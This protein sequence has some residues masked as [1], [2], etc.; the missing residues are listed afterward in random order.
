MRKTTACLLAALLLL[1]LVG[2]ERAPEVSVDSPETP[3]ASQTNVAPVQVPQK[4]EAD[5]VEAAFGIPIVLPANE[6]WIAED[7]YRLTGETDLKVTYRDMIAESECTL[8]VLKGGDLELPEVEFDEALNESWSGETLGGQ[9]VSVDVRHEKAQPEM[10]L[11]A[12]EYGEYSFQLSGADDENVC[13]P[14]VA[15]SVIKNLQ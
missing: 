13:I 3:A 11:A 6:N 5:E 10:T 8:L 1:S 15:L 12:W 4:L 2:C 14:K 9:N 7:S